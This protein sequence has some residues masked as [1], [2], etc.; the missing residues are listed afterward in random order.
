ME[1][2]FLLLYDFSI[3]NSNSTI[4]SYLPYLSKSIMLPPDKY[5]GTAALFSYAMAALIGYPSA[6]IASPS[7]RG[8]NFD[9]WFAI[10]FILGSVLTFYSALPKRRQLLQINWI[11]IPSSCFL[12]FLVCALVNPKSVLDNAGMLLL[13][14]MFTG[15]A[16]LWLPFMGLVL[17]G[18]A[19]KHIASEQ[20]QPIESSGES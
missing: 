15:G 1:V 3:S 8:P 4:N 7:G 14:T 17:H 12:M 13:F 5:I 10:V 20:P 9:L 11:I 2:S 6:A 16:P 18:K 19:C